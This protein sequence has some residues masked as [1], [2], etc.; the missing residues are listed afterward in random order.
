MAR[1]GRTYVLVI[2]SALLLGT[3][4][5]VLSQSERA[6]SDAGPPLVAASIFGA[7]HGGWR[8]RGAGRF[9]EGGAERHLGKLEEYVDAFGGF[10]AP[11]RAAWD[12]LV[13]SLRASVLLFNDV[14]AELETAERESTAPG[15]LALAEEAIQAA[16][17]AM[18]KV[19][20]SF[21]AFYATLDEDQRALLDRAFAHGEH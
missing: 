4:F 9:C 2:A 18:Q 5:I 13:G 11:Q 14:C 17:A 7:S 6:W 1:I 15:R 3:V 21:E 12:E 19:R 10:T 16:A 8:H 20:P